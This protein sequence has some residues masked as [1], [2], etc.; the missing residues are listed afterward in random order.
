[1]TVTIIPSDITATLT[2]YAYET[3][4]GKGIVAGQTKGPDVTALD[5]AHLGRLAAGASATPAWRMKQTSATT[6]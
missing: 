5:P 1:M 3:I 2:G 4:P 6:H